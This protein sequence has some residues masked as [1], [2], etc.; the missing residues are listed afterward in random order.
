MS[1]TSFP[2]RLSS[3]ASLLMVAFLWLSIGA[4]AQPVSIS[5]NAVHYAGRKLVVFQ[6]DDYL[7]A[8][9]SVIHTVQIPSN[10][11]FSFSVNTTIA[12][13][14]ILAIGAAEATLHASPGRTYKVE[15]PAPDGEAYRRFDRTPVELQ[16]TDAADNEVNLLIRAYNRDHARFIAD[17]YYQFAV[18]SYKGSEAYRTQVAQRGKPTDLVGLTEARDTSSIIIQEELFTNLVQVFTDRVHEKYGRYMGDPYFRDYVR[19]SLAELDLVSGQRRAYLYK[20]YLHN[21]PVQ[22][23]HPVYMK[24][25]GLFY[26]GTV[27]DPVPAMRRELNA[28]INGEKS[29][30]RLAALYTEDSLYRNEKLRILSVIKGLRDVR[31]SADYNPAHIE[32][33]LDEISAKHPDEEVRM[34][35]RRTL[36][37]MRRGKAGSTIEEFVLLNEKNDIWKWGDHQGEYTYFLFFADWC[38]ACKK[39]MIVMEKLRKQYLK[40]IR[41]VAICMDEDYESFRNY[42]SENR[43]QRPE[44]LF[45]GNDPLLRQK[46]GLRAIPHAVLVDPEGKIVSEY[47]R[48]PSEGIQT[49]FERIEKK[50]KENAPGSGTWREK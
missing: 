12:R 41:F 47:T 14:L 34:I 38:T 22:T 13:E 36:A 48:R 44:I 19:Y 3:P 2:L 25:F 35:A 28:R 24:F 30:T 16:F 40:H 18:G 27:S 31:Y 5:G 11:A 9:R 10:G 4:I 8:A 43:D 29:G 46:F 7:S 6:V 42:I 50:L 23:Q 26:T 20:E 15:I 32:A 45:G 21:Q 39:D 33:C 17:H 1:R 37:G 49:E